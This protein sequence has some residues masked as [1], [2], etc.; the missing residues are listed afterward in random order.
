MRILDSLGTD[1]GWHVYYSIYKIGFNKFS[2]P[3]YSL[4][5]TR[6]II[7]RSFE[8]G[9]NFGLGNTNVFV[10][11]G[12]KWVLAKSIALGALKKYHS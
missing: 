10:K 12:D 5:K 2:V 1:S 8:C 9:G 7:F 11:R 4:D 6:C 3:L